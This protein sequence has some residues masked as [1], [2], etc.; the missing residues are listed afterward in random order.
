LTRHRTVAAGRKLGGALVFLVLV[1]LGAALFS[2][3]FEV[4]RTRD[5]VWLSDRR[6]GHICTIGLEA[7]EPPCWS[8]FAALLARSGLVR[9]EGAAWSASAIALRTAHGGIENGCADESVWYVDRAKNI[10]LSDGHA[11]TT[12]ALP[13]RPVSQDDAVK[14]C[15]RRGNQSLY[16]LRLKS[17][18]TVTAVRLR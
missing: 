3:R 2:I 12:R 6:S 8:E 10:F 16:T 1:L 11:Y 5:D 4:L 9:P 15:S 17:N 7:L 14:V 18:L 13:S